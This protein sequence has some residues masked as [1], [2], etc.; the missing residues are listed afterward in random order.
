MLAV[1]LAPQCDDCQRMLGE[2]VHGEPERTGATNV[3]LSSRVE[4]LEMQGKKTHE[5]QLRI[6]EKKDDMPDPRQPARDTEPAHIAARSKRQSEFDVSRSGMNQ[7][8][9]DNKHNQ[10]GQSGHKPQQHSPAE[11]KN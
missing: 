4:E 11:E 2:R 1:R 10:R 8:S 7:E 6:L 5:Q 3:F 9:D